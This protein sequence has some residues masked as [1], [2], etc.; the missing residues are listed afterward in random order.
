[1]G[2][3]PAYQRRMKPTKPWAL[4]P[5]PLANMFFTSP[6]ESLPAHLSSFISLYLNE[7]EFTLWPP[8]WWTCFGRLTWW[9]P[10]KPS[11]T[12]GLSRVS[13]GELRILPTSFLQS[14]RCPSLALH[15]SRCNVGMLDP[16]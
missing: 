5:N 7:L 11:K 14:L 3:P 13:F 10:K 16:D 6:N 8:N 4:L 9:D 12:T 1:M 15:C 2:E